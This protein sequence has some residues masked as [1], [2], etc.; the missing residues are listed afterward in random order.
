MPLQGRQDTL[1]DVWAD[2]LLQPA[3]SEEDFARVATMFEARRTP[4]PWTAGGEF[5]ANHT[6]DSVTEILREISVLRSKSS[7]LAFDGM[8]SI[9]NVASLS[10][11][12]G[13]TK[14]TLSR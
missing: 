7:R 13:I 1:L 9:P 11:S 8:D 5:V 3:F 10:D 6:A 4:G 12:P 14:V 2:V